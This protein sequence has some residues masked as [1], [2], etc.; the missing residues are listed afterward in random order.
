[1]ATLARLGGWAN[2]Y[3]ALSCLLGALAIVSSLIPS[4][5][6]INNQITGRIRTPKGPASGALVSP[7]SH[8]GL[9]VQTDLSGNYSIPRQGQFNWIAALEGHYLEPTS[10]GDLLL[11]PLPKDH[12]DSPWIDPT[13]GASTKACGNCHQQAFAH[14]QN[15]AHQKSA[16]GLIL[17]NML[18]QPTGNQNSWHLLATHPEGAAACIAC[19]APGQSSL[20]AELPLQGPLS[21]THCDLCHKVKAL[22]SGTPGLTHGRDLFEFARP[23]TSQRPVVIGPLVDS[24]RENV[25][26]SS[27]FKKS[28]ICSPCHEGTVLGAK[29]YT[30]FSE[31]QAWGGSQTCQDCHMPAISPREH[32]HEMSASLARQTGGLRARWSTE[33]SPN[34][35]IV[36]LDIWAEGLGHA[37][38]TGHI[39]RHILGTIMATDA[40]NSPLNS[41]SADNLVPAW[42]SGLPNSI[43]GFLLARWQQ[44]NGTAP[45]PFWMPGGNWYDSRLLPASRKH[46]TWKF[47]PQ[48]SKLHLRIKH[49]R[50]WPELLRQ[51]NLTIPSEVLWDETR[52]LN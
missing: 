27:L 50:A 19:H 34:A 43:P 12:P 22:A 35:L 48:T 47:P 15:S 28:Q 24:T 42:A 45:H 36:H 49:R 13:P 14:W 9:A 7:A 44:I 46:F 30:S 17:Q 18:A 8:S 20:N 3:S 6:P 5:I 21:G 23:A 11:T 37:L 52:N 41:L 2:Q 26:Y 51:N 38:P 29:V 33:K 1:M 40:N 32:H 25:A 16:S 31:W 39:D 10:G 4:P